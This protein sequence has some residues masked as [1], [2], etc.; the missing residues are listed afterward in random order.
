MISK[1]DLY[2]VTYIYYNINGTPNITSYNR[3]NLKGSL[4]L[5]LTHELLYTLKE[6]LRYKNI[7]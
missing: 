3:L 1:F 6:N 4:N 5:K 7:E 2:K